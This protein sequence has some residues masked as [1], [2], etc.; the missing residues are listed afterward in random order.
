MNFDGACG[1]LG[2]ATANGSGGT[3]PY[4]YLWNNNET[5]RTITNLPAGTYSVTITDENNCETTGSATVSND[6]TAFQ[7]ADVVQNVSCHNA[8]DGSINLQIVQGTPPYDV[9]WSNGSTELIQTGLP[10][11]NYTV[12]IMDGA[13]CNYISQYE[14]QSPGQMNISFDTALPQAG[15]FNGSIMANVNGG[16]APYSYNW[17]TGQSGPFIEGLDFGVY[18][19]TIT[20]NNGCTYTESVSLM[21]TSS[22]DIEGLANWKIFPNPS[23]GNVFID[24]QLITPKMLT[25]QLYD[26]RGVLIRS[27]ENRGDIF[28]EKINVDQIAAGTYMVVLRDEDGNM[29]RDKLVVIR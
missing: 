2:G 18:D 29:E 17:S 5:E 12:Q 13:G 26:I 15:E 11:G 10:A 27:I 14:V 24:I 1:N 25:I 21:T 3:P 9:L 22:Y 6:G 19:V 16:L 20:D 28:N 23:S 7:V 4:S 8:S